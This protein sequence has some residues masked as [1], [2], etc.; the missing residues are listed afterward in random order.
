MKDVSVDSPFLVSHDGKL[1]YRDARTKP[2]KKAPS[3]AACERDLPKIVDSIA[4]LQ[5]KLY[6]E[7]TWSVLLMFQAMD[8]AG[9]DGTIRAVMSGVDPSGCDVHSFKQPSHDELDHDF[10]WREAIHLPQRG[11]IGI[12]NRSWYEEVLVVRVHPEYLD[13]QRLPYRPKKL[14]KLCAQR[15]ESIRDFEK[16]LARNGTAIVKFWLHVSKREQKKRFLE[17]ID[18]ESHNWKF[19]EADVEERGRWDDYMEA[20]E[21]ALRETSRPWAPWYVIPA[22]SKPYMRYSVARIIE[23]TF[24]RLHPSFPELPTDKRR[25]L[26]AVRRRLVH[27]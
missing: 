19:S 25:R 22:D 15:Y 26:L 12:F 6:A 27:E 23:A 20:Y 21:D 3:D 2:P 13:G 9:K 16:H 18:D 10:L 5:R 1:S 17:R 11:R 24:E 7:D 8:A 14:A 4:K